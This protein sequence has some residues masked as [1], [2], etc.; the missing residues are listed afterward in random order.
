MSLVIVRHAESLWNVK[1]LFTGWLDIDLTQNGIKSAK[2]LSILLKDE[3]YN[4]EYIF[5]SDLIRTI[6]TAEFIC[7]DNIKETIHSPYLRERDY[8]NLTGMNKKSAEELLG[9]EL[10]FKIRRGFYD[11]PKDGESLSDVTIR[12][13]N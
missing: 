1:D 7:R 5:T 2:E 10:F 9:S 12:V 8:G 13:G 11:K 6:N 4:F 3:N